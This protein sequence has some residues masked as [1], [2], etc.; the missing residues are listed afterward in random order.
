MYPLKVINPLQTNR[1]IRGVEITFVESIRKKKGWPMGCG[2]RKNTNTRKARSAALAKAA[3]KARLAAKAK[4]KGKNAS[5][6]NELAAR[7]AKYEHIANKLTV[8]KAC[9]HSQQS[10]LDKKR[11]IRRCHKLNKLIK[12]ISVDPNIKCPTGQF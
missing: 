8:C 7:K 10:E 3:H 4:K 1:L 5:N 2:C 9:P 12:D 11:L 6:G